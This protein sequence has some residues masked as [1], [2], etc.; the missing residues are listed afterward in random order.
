MKKWA[1]SLL[2]AAICTVS[3]QN[4]MAQSDLGFKAIGAQIG[5]VSPENLDTT[6]GL[7]IFADHGYLTPMIKL[8]SHIDYWGWSEDFNGGTTSIRDIAIGARCKYMFE[9][10]SPKIRPFAGAGLGIH[11]LHAEVD[12]PAQ[13]FGG[14]VVPAQHAE[15]STTRLGLD[16][17]GGM[18]MPVNPNANFLAEAWYGI[19]SDVSHISIRVGMSWNLSQQ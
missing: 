2:L 5:M 15:D 19:V 9:T 16:I 13:D 18:E 6:F 3:A 10:S 1:V 17:G 14:F 8:E 4:A 7:G 12:I 11:F